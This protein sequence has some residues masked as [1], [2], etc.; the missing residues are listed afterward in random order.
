MILIY[1]KRKHSTSLLPCINLVPQST[2]I[3]AVADAS[4]RLYSTLTVLVLLEACVM[5][6]N[7]HVGV[8]KLSRW[9]G[10]I[11]NLHQAGVVLVDRDCGIHL[12]MVV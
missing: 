3:I 10:I 4:I 11:A 7:F 12:E 5:L 9:L 1:L 6:Q 2:T 8:R